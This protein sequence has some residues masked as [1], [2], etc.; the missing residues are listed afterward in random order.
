M[1]GDQHSVL[2]RLVQLLLLCA[3][4]CFSVSVSAQQAEGEFEH[5]RIAAI[6]EHKTLA[7]GQKTRIAIRLQ[8][9][10]HWHTYW[11]FPGDSGLPTKL[12]L[13]INARE[14]PVS[15]F[16]PTPK[17][18]V[19]GGIHNVG[20]EGEAILLAD[21]T[22]PADA[23][24][25]ANIALDLSWLV[26]KE[27]C[28][29]GR[30]TLSFTLP[31]ADVAETD[32]E[33]AQLFKRAESML[34]APAPASVRAQF[35]R[36][37]QRIWIQLNAPAALLVER[38]PASAQRQL[39]VGDNALAAVAQSAIG[40]SGDTLSTVRDQHE[41]FVAEPAA[42]ELVW[43]AET[44]SG[45]RSAL[46]VM[47]TPAARDISGEIAALMQSAGTAP[48]ST[49]Q[50]SPG[51]TS[52]PLSQSFIAALLLAFGGGL[53]LNLMPCVFPVLSLKVMGFLDVSPSSVRVQSISYSA[54]V[55]VSFLSLG[56]LW[57]S[58][59]SAGQEL[60]WGF[61]LQSSPLIA[62]LALLMFVLGLSMSG[63][64][65]FGYRLQ[66]LGQ[67]VST[68]DSGWRGAFFNGVLACV[69]ASPCTAPMM[70]TALGYALVQPAWICLSVLLALGFGFAAPM[71]LLAINPALS[72]KLPKPGAW[73]QTTKQALAI[74]M[75]LSAIWLLW[76]LGQQRDIDS[77][78]LVL[79]AATLLAIGLIWREQLRF[80]ER[81]VARVAAIALAGLALLPLY[82]A[83]RAPTASDVTWQP[84]SAEALQTLQQQ[85]KPVLVQMTAAWCVTCK[86]NERVAMSGAQFAALL[87]QHQ[88]VAMKGDWTSEDAKI[89]SYLRSFGASG[90]PLVVLYSPS[91]ATEVLPQVLTP[92]IVEA[93][94][95]RAT[96]VDP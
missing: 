17:A 33:Q 50:V 45:Q 68:A 56:L 77:V 28:I 67:Q 26:C 85:Q 39:F 88:V 36:K 9:E 12:S 72:A 38:F 83:T 13:R 71:L 16:W 60:G 96:G 62:T 42:L 66:S 23:S 29:P 70:G 58:V 78:A 93:A 20:Y 90:V 18:L 43:V 51:S 6:A 79:V 84:Y 94:V 64:V 87:K 44:P 19:V 32:A 73:M 80:S 46:S 37:D 81:S 54:G 8:H 4:A 3:L 24:D 10:K 75:Y 2:Q 11:K 35:Y 92:S 14:Q 61:Q 27:E 1:R 55:I 57:L 82:A 40:Q 30:G 76:V 47:A 63:L 74:P 49:A 25:Q 15:L 59:R 95:L 86:V 21:F 65:H 69:I 89:T 5:L 53:I 52:Q 31:V 7:P 41:S 34:P 91:G 22:V 48:G